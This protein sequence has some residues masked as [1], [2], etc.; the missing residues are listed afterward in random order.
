MPLSILEGY[1]AKKPVIATD[2]PGTR[3]LVVSDQTGVLIPPKDSFRL[4][5]A[6]ER[7]M[8]DLDGVRN[9]GEAGY[10]MWR[11]KFSFETMVSNYHQLYEG[12]L[13]DHD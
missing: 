13:K 10:R 7:W 12:I 3:S 1:S 6:V 4:R 11:E 2:I 8:D 5:Q 9:M